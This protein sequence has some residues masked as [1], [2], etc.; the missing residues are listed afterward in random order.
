MLGGW[1]GCWRSPTRSPT[2]SGGPG[3]AAL[4]PDL[5][6]AAGDLPWDYLE[7][8]A[9][10]LDRPVVFV[11]GN[12]DPATSRAR[13]HRSG[14]FL[15]A[16]MPCEPPRPAGCLQRRR[17]GA[18]RGRAAHRRAGRLRALP[19]RPEP[20]Q[21]AR[22]PPAGRA[23]WCAGSG[24]AQRRRPGPVDVLLTHAPPRGL[25]D[26]EDRPHVGI[27]ALHPLLE[28]LRP[29]LAPARAHPPARP[30]A[31]RPDRRRHYPAER[32]PVPADRDHAGRGDRRPRGPAVLRDTGS[33]RA[34]AENDF[35]RARRQ[36]V[37]A[38]LAARMLGKDSDDRK[39]LPFQEVVDALGLVSEVSL[40]I[41]VI[42]VDRIVGSVDKVRD[43]D[44][45]FRPTSGSSR[46]RWERIAEAARR[47]EPLPPIDVYQI[48]EHVLRA[49]RAPPGVGV[50]VA[51]AGHDRGRR[52]AGADPRRS[53]RRARPLRPV[54]PGAAP[55][56]DAAGAAGQGRAP[57]AAADRRRR[58]TRGWPRWW[59]PGRPG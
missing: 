51:R 59:R 55:A 39:A 27:E 44:P 34:D 48:G 11:P 49:R 12:H 16:G 53:G 26:E 10:A 37:L 1:S 13:Q 46:R 23:A 18:R 54:R 45:K 19:A 28:R 35:L 7:F 2:R 20:V 29:A 5:V 38:G 25:G 33:P 50:P 41:Q 58:G 43:F 40:G 6:L 9:S 30:P 8:L 32:D 3:S 14:Q 21:P 47:G 17:H 57:R 15:H 56:A 52:A 22:V 31:P 4:A 42:P 24:G 36:Q